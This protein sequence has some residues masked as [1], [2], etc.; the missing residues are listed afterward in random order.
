MQ[1]GPPLARKQCVLHWACHRSLDRCEPCR[2]I[3][4]M[5]EAYE[6]LCSGCCA[7]AAATEQSYR[8]A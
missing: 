2:L 5:V 1:K 7:A 3:M 4:H 6:G 8:I